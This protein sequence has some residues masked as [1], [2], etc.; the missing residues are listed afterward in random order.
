MKS[1]TVCLAVV[2]SCIPAIHA[3]SQADR[4]VSPPIYQVTVTQS[5]I[6]AVNY[7]HR[8]G[9]PT[10]IDFR[11]TVLMPLAKG[12]A[13]VESKQGATSI[14][15]KLEGL[16]P[17]TRFGPE[18]LTYVLWA[19]TP[20]GRPVNLGELV[21]DASNKARVKV[22][23]RLQAFGLLVSAEPYYAVTEPGNLVIA[24]NVVRPD[25]AGKAEFI[26]V[27]YELLPGRG[28]ARVNLGPPTLIP[29][30]EKVPLDEYAAILELY[31]AR[32]AV[33]IARTAGADRYA[34]D[35]LSRAEQLLQQAEGYRAS[36]AGS[37]KTVAAAKE[38]AQAAEDARSIAIKRAGDA[39]ASARR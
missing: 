32:N 3:Q 14:D 27:K 25:T 1:V 10:K 13:K 35:T 33:Q 18:Y 12:E 21:A 30:G 9:Q 37:K 29:A 15:M 2:C 20:E 8:T 6:K 26:D 38:A 39:E 23:T 34:A 17:P 31:Q 28:T 22:T 5:T 4:S 7:E 19:I 11:G 16:E 36:K 24:E